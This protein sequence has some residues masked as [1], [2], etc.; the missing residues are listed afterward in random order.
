MDAIKQY[1]AT[2][3]LDAGSSIK[4]VV[5]TA[6]AATSTAVIRS[7]GGSG[8]ILLTLSAVANTSA[9]F[10]TPFVCG[11]NAHITLTGA[12]AIASVVYV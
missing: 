10:E 8:T 11:N 5:L 6:A 3:A 12:G 9:T 1:T 2:G 7:G 4:A